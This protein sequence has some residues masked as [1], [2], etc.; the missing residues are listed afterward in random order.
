MQQSIFVQMASYR[1]PQLIPTLQDMVRRAARPECLRIVVCWQHGL[2]EMIGRFFSQ[3]FSRWQVDAAGERP[4][5][6]LAL[7]EATVELID[8]P[9]MET[10]GACWARNM[11]QQRYGGEAYTLQVDSHHRFIRGWDGVVVDMLESLRAESEKPVLTAYLPEFHPDDDPARRGRHPATL[12]FDRFIPEGAVFVLPRA[13][14]DWERHDK[15]LR[16]RFYSAHF[17]FADGHFATAVQHDPEYFFHGEE[18]SIAARAFTHGYD[19][20]HPHRLIAWHEYT[21]RYRVKMWDDHTGANTGNGVVA[22]PW[23]ERNALSHRRNRILFGMDGESSTSI[24]FGPYG[25]G[26]V[27]SL[28]QYEAYAGI[29]FALRSVK[30]AVLEGQLPVQGTPVPETEAEYRESL[31]RSHDVDPRFHRDNLGDL[32][33]VERVDFTVFSEK[34]EVMH[35][36]SMST[37]EIAAATEHGW[38]PDRFVFF[39]ALDMVPARYTARFRAANDVTLR[40]ATF[41]IA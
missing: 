22:K 24:D 28:A 25:F 32:S 39:S 10:Q 37:A 30:R 12:H 26:P 17:A 4:V 33:N 31:L 21:R 7:G 13:I 14:P 3:G 18:I 1:D 38:L 40:E 15:P 16:A 5:H 35:R 34:D 27:R 19:L 23:Y 41:P 36:E 2:D 11:I 9:A 8:V 6:T 20:Y 29:S